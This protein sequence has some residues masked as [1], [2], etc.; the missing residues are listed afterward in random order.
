MLDEQLLVLGNCYF[1][2]A[3]ITT[4]IIATQRLLKHLMQLKKGQF[5]KYYKVSLPYSSKPQTKF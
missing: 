1:T 2:I 4:S 3:T 5:L